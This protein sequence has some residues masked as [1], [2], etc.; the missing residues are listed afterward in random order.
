MKVLL[1]RHG[2]ST[3]N[4]EGR[5]VGHGADGLTA[6]GRTQVEQLARWLRNQGSPTHIYT[7]PLR[8][9][10]ETLEILVTVGVGSTGLPQG[11]GTAGASQ[12]LV[13]DTGQTIVV[14]A[15]AAIAEFQA[16]IFTGLTWSEAQAQYPALC[17]ALETNRDWIP[18]PEAE[19]PQSGRDRAQAFLQDLLTQHQDQDVLWVISHQWILEH[20]VAQVMGCDRTWQIPMANTALFEF[21]LDL[22]R[23][24]QTDMARHTSNLWQIRHFG[25]CPHLG[26]Q[27]Y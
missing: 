4:R 19:T 8:R 11:W 18:I 22:G 26:E 7:S 21:E 25:T 23:W 13:E 10:V 24:P 1:I 16:G 20:L 2:E 15:T 17:T 5:M 3:G 9:A 14:T 27:F 6:R 12:Y